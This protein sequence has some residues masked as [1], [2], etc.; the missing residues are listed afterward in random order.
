MLWLGHSKLK[1]KDPEERRQTAEKLGV[2][3]NNGAVGPLTE[4]LTDEDRSVREAA[5]VALGK[6]GDF[7]A[8][9]SLVESLLRK[10]Y[11]MVQAKAAIALGRIGDAGGLP[12]LTKAFNKQI[13]H[14][15]VQEGSHEDKILTGLLQIPELDIKET[16]A[17]SVFLQIASV[18]ALA[19]TQNSKVARRL[20]EWLP[21]EKS[22]LMKYQ[23]ANSL[24]RFGLPIETRKIEEELSVNMLEIMSGA[25]GHIGDVGTY[26]LKAIE[27]LLCD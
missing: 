13:E 16:D 3:R 6:I 18:I 5:A 8:T 25:E 21:N 7:N 10:D 20:V 9:Q 27:T 26:A 22:D 19:Q 24:K 23:I 12:A 4:V 2:P 17:Q 11:V 15:P 1:S 14:L